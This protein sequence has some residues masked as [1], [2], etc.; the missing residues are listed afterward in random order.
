ML[1]LTRSTISATQ[2]RLR[3]GEVI[4]NASAGPNPVVVEKAGIPVVVILSLPD[5]EQLLQDA[6]LGRFERL[7]RAAG[8]DAERQGLSEEHLEEEMAQIKE[9]VYRRHYG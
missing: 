1:Q 3:F 6:K 2:A 4:R 8:L 5:Y 9:H 7:S